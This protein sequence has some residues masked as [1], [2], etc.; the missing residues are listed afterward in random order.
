M[1]GLVTVS[2]LERLIADIADGKVIILEFEVTKDENEPDT[3]ILIRFCPPGSGENRFVRTLMEKFAS[4]PGMEI[5]MGTDCC[6][7][8]PTDA[9]STSSST[10]EKKEETEEVPH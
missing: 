3:S 9:D 10:D 4:F 5:R 7:G 1:I 2:A 6:G 8:A